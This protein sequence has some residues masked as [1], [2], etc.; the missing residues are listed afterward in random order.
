M[1]KFT[2]MLR[3]NTRLRAGE[4]RKTFVLKTVQNH[5]NYLLLSYTLFFYKN[6][7]IRTRL[8][9][10]QKLRISEEQSRLGF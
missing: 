7:F 10:A 4:C 9:F 2:F 6:N 1:P 3:T 8:K 5:G